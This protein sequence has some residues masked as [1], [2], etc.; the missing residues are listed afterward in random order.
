MI[1]IAILLVVFL[2][3]IN[4]AGDDLLYEFS[5]GKHLKLRNSGQKISL[6]VSNPTDKN[7][8]CEIFSPK[9][10]DRP[11]NE[12]P[13]IWFRP[14]EG[15]TDCLGGGCTVIPSPNPLSTAFSSVGPY[16]PGES[17]TCEFEVGIL[18]EFT[19]TIRLVGNGGSIEVTR[20]VNL[21][22]SLNKAGLSIL[23]VSLLLLGFIFVT[24]SR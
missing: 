7:I 21:I 10:I 23:F 8:S 3:A 6:T 9:D 11:H 4:F 13:R 22:P 16:A 24:R 12:V 5:F 15:S 17:K 20:V 14:V 1:R 18:Q 19:G 2:P